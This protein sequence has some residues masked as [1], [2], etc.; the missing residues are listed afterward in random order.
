MHGPGTDLF[1]FFAEKVK[2][3]VPEAVGALTLETRV[4]K[5]ECSSPMPP[6]YFLYE[7]K[8]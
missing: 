4:P 1:T 3:M 7:Y 5:L 6:L 2:E 8:S